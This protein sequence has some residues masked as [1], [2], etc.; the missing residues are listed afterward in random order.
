MAHPIGL[1]RKNIKENKVQM[2]SGKLDDPIHLK[3]K[4]ET[5]Q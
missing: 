5:Q 1:K 3:Y 2:R 4:V